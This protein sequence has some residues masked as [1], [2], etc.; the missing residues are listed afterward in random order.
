MGANMRILSRVLLALALIAPARAAEPPREAAIAAAIPAIDRL[1]DDYRLDAHVPGLVYGIV[2]DGRLIHLRATG[3]QDLT[4]RRPVTPDS[5]FRIASMTKAFTALSILSLRDAGKLSLDA[6]AETYVP[7]LKG[8]RYP[9]DDSPRLRVRDL[10][11]HSAGFVTDDPWGDRQQ[12]LSDAAF[13][14]MLRNGVPFTRAPGTA[15]E[16]SNFG[17]ALLG[18]IVTNVAR[19]PFDV[20]AER[21]LLGPLGMATS[22]YEIGDV[23]AERLAVG[24]RWENERWSSEPTMPHGAF[25][26][27]GG[28][29]TTANDYA[30]YV[31]WLLDAWPPRDGADRGPVRRASVRELA[32]G[33]N[34]QSLVRRPGHSGDACRQAFAYGMGMRTM[35]DCDI[36][37]AL[38]HGGGYPGYG[39]YVL[40]LPEHGVGIFAFANRTYAGP[41]GPVWDAALTLHKAGALTGRSAPVSADL[42]TAYSAAGAIYKAGDV[43]AGGRLLAMNFLM[44]RSAENWRAELGRLKA[45]V[46]D[47]DTAAPVTTTGA[48]SGRFTWRCAHGRLEGTLLLAPTRPA[49]IQS[50]RLGV[51]GQ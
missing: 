10:L 49:S 22:G 11:N 12:A 45:Q 17:Y 20:Y 7:E 13:T 43:A 50:L 39:S 48:L 42:A 23:P 14:A 8:W 34:L 41:S 6:P 40:L 47:C 28:L 35:A 25:G 37:L 15:H 5:V 33:S 31:A 3:V 24:Y 21:T 16:Y 4:A 1:F 51:A 9:T 44:D 19:Q 2:A 26:A 27:M 38:G 29:H 36:G 30:K 32:Q 18:R 46:G